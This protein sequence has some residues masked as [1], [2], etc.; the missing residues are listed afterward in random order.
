MAGFISKQPNGLYCRFST[1]TDCPT[2]WNMTEDDYI[3][4]C[5]RKAEKEA[6]EV[7]EGYLQPFEMVEERFYPNNM[8]EEEFKQF[9]EDVNQKVGYIEE[10]ATEKEL[11][12]CPFC[13]SEAILINVK[14]DDGD[15][16]YRPE[17]SKCKCGWQENYETED[18][19]IDAWNVRVK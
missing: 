19:A 6:K 2:D 4:L 11:E 10:V 14:F 5:K 15:I 13:G 12:S 17:C 3:R 18:E 16:Y 8:S 7:L 1:I 9:L